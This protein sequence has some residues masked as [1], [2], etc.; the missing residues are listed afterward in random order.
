ML[1]HLR[2]GYR[3]LTTKDDVLIISSTGEVAAEEDEYDRD[4]EQSNS[5]SRNSGSR[6]I[7]S[8]LG[9]STYL[10]ALS[11][12][13]VAFALPALYGTLSKLWTVNIDSSQVVMTDVY[14]YI[15]VVAEVLNEGLPRTAWLLIGD[16]KNR[17]VPSRLSLSYTLIFVQALLGLFMTLIFICAADRVAA[18]WVPETVRANSLTYVRISSMQALTSAIEIAVANC[19]RALDKPDVPLLI[20]STKFVANIVL[21]LLLISPFHVGSFTPTTTVQAL[22]RMSCDLV[23]AF[24]GLLYFILLSWKLHRLSA[25]DKTIRPSISDLKILTPPRVSTLLESAIR[26]SLYLWLVSGVVAMG[27]DYATAWGVFNTIRWGMVMVPVQALEASALAFVGHG[28]GTWR[29]NAG[30]GMQRPKASI[31]DL[32]SIAKPAVASASLALLVEIPLCI[33]LS[34]GGVRRFAYYLSGTEPVASITE[35]MW[36]V[37]LFSLTFTSPIAAFSTYCYPRSV[38]LI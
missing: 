16:K 1:S 31:S 33:G 23:A 7:S 27:S 14:T 26:N 37:S 21:D 12:N 34:L 17:T 6:S 20:S 25:H 9:R 8:L 3:M 10:G 4:H 36:R 11:F 35:K 18:A 38:L 24:A 5:G 2:V 19:T 29:S 22:I 13:I 28:W 15:G 30:I 32:R